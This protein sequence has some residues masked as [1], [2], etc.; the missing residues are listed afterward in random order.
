MTAERATVCVV[1]DDASVRKALTRL[2]L[3]AGLDVKT[4]A[5]AR[6]FLDQGPPQG[7]GCLVLDVR[8]PDLSGLDLQAA[9]AAQGITLPIVFITGH[10]DIPTSVQAMKGGAVDFL[11]KPFRNKDLLVV[12]EE[13]IRRGECLKASQAEKVEV[14]RRL[15]TLTP[16]ERE[17][18]D[19]M[20]KGLLNKQIAAELGAAVKTIKVH[21]GRVMQKMQVRSVA[22]LVHGV[23]QLNRPADR[24]PYT[25]KV[26]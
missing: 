10:G 2:I 13:A 5:S 20:V 8:L 16:R 18:L 7:Q 26:S 4:F 6:E 11:T 17:V 14:Q 3:A 24:G 22:E 1:D 15:Q 25:T 9:L 23:E 19:L 21:R 12:V